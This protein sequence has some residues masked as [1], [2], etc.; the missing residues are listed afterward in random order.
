MAESRDKVLRMLQDAG[1]RGVTTGEFCAAYIERFSARILELRSER[2][3]GYDIRTE[4]LGRST[5]RYVLNPRPA[6]AAAPLGVPALA[7]PAA[8]PLAASQ[9]R[10]ALFD[11]DEAAA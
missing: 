1:S 3:G 10:C 5:F 4:R 6:S 9:P 8:L 7:P 11:Y 2:Y